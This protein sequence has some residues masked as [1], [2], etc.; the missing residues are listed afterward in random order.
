V[1]PE[2]FADE[3]LA[4]L[5]GAQL[6][7]QQLGHVQLD[8]NPLLADSYSV[9]LKEVRLRLLLRLLMMMWLLLRWCCIMCVSVVGTRK[10]REC[11]ARSNH[12]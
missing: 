10:C 7:Y 2:A 5:W 6:R 4:R 11:A 12:R 1:L 8:P 9:F 3:Q